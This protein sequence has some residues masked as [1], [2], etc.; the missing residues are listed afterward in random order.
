MLFK[1]KTIVDVY[2][3]ILQF[4][5]NLNLSISHY[6]IHY[7]FSIISYNKQTAALRIFIY[8]LLH[9]YLSAYLVRNNKILTPVKNFLNKLT[10]FDHF[11]QLNT[12]M[13]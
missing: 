8:Q 3:E 5:Y 10:D 11:Y 7:L 2:S 9:L 13:L 1:N 6:N 4:I 12:L